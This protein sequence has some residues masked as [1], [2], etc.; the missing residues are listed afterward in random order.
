MVSINKNKCIGCGSCVAICDEV[1]EMIGD[2]AKVKK[3]AKKDSKCIKEAINSC[4]VNAI[5]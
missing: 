4:P 2:K 3:D 5:K 1:F